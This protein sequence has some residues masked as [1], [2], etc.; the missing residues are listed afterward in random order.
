MQKNFP[1]PPNPLEACCFHFFK[2]SLRV[3]LFLLQLLLSFG[4]N[5]GEVIVIFFILAFREP[6]D[7]GTLICSFLFILNDVLYICIEFLLGTD[8]MNILDHLV[9]F[10]VELRHVQR[11]LLFLA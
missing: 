11:K 9:C 1:V 8:L 5:K 3:G 4:W 2:L 10:D 6:P 7:D